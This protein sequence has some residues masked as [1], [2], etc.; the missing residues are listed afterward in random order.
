MPHLRA[1]NWWW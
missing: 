1:L